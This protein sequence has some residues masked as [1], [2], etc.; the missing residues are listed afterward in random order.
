MSSVPNL[1]PRIQDRTAG[2]TRLLTLQTSVDDVISW[3][4]SFVTNPD[5]EAGDGIRQRLTVSLL[6]KG[7]EQRDR[8]ELAQVLEDCGAK[9]NLTSDGLFVEVSGQARKKDVGKVINVLAEM[10]RAPAFSETEFE[11]ARAQAAADIQRRME[12]TSVQAASALSQRLFDPGHPNY[13]RAPEEQLRRLQSVTLEDIRAYHET[14][15]GADEW[16]LAVVGDLKHET[17]ASIV[18]DAFGG[19]PTHNTPATHG[20][21]SARRTAG[22]SS[23]PMPDKSSVDVR[24]GH[25]LP[26]RRDHEE[27]EALYLGNYVLGGNFSARLMNTVRDEMGLTYHVG[28]ALAGFSTRYDG[29]WQASVTLSPDAVDPGI[30]ATRDVIRTFVDEGATSE[31]LQAKKTTIVGSYTVGLATTRRL[32]Q[33][34]LTTAERGFDLEYVDRFPEKIEALTLDEVNEAVQKHLRPGDLHEAL[35]GTEPEPVGA[36]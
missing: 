21:A 7:T 13:N 5:L 2:R 14:H 4:G 29:Y 33:S 35:A 12:K 34:I 16:T 30:E 25:G 22:R 9:L 27:Y 20:T 32:A 3:R 10:L 26:I 31:E 19:W 18:E 1:S 8:F 36:E 23:V 6:D 24:M 11:K 17:I 15:F 28:S